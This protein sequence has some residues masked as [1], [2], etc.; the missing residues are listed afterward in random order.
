MASSKTVFVN[1]FDNDRQPKL[2]IW[3]PKPE[4]QHQHSN[5]CCSTQTYGLY[6]ITKDLPYY[7][8]YK[9]FWF[10]QPYCYSRLSVVVPIIW[11]H[12]LWARRG[13][14]LKTLSLELQ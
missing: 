10:G 4:R 3:P 9:Y 12:F 8:R 14:K 7:Q 1:D 13:R 5:H 2:A 11:G 6:F